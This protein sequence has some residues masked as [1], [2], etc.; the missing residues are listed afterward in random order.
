MRGWRVGVALAAM[1]I[2]APAVAA[3][4]APATLT[5]ER[6]FASPD[7]AGAQPQSLRLSPDGT[8]V[9]SV[10]AR[11]DERTRFDLWA[12]DTRTGAERMLLDSRKVGSGAALS[13]A[14]GLWPDNPRLPTARASL[15]DMGAP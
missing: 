12:L 1:V 13:E 8:L 9:T 4:D 5:L 2:G 3:E 11:A 15:H 6:V 14:E 7:L 10:R